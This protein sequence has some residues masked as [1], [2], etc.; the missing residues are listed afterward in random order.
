MRFFV[1]AIVKILTLCSFGGPAIPRRGAGWGRAFFGR[2][3]DLDRALTR[4][5]RYFPRPRASG[6]GEWGFD[7]LLFLS[8]TWC[9]VTRGFR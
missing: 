1:F 2:L 5:P 4:F 7:V 9:W 3:P 8:R 6:S